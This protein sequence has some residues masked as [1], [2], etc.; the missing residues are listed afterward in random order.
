MAKFTGLVG[1]V[2]QEELVPGVWSP[3]ENPKQMKG[4]IIRQASSSQHDYRDSSGNK[5]NND[6]SL[7]HR[8]SLLGDAYAFDNYFNL[9]WIEMNNKK[10]AISSVELQRPRI[11]VSLGGL[12]NA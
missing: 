8:V 12:W 1:Y 11:I 7:N 4:D 9:K 10:W 6:I 5:V 2:T 3:V